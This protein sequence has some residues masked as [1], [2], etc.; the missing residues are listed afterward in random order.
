[1]SK[2]N[3]STELV[4]NGGFPPIYVCKDKIK[5]LKDKAHDEE[6]ATKRQ[7]KTHKTSVSI[8]KIMEQRRNVNPFIKT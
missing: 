6:E 4:P 1:M 8:K 5:R 2:T 7:Y 3:K